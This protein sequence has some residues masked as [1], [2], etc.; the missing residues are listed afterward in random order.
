MVQDLA[1]QARPVPQ[2]PEVKII[3]NAKSSLATVVP[4]WQR[5]AARLFRIAVEI[6]LEERNAALSNRQVR[7][8]VSSNRL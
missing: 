5:S 6:I 8:T 7:R 4:V 3:L 1:G 2:P